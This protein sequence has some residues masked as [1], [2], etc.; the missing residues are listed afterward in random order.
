MPA[1]AV[2]DVFDDNAWEG[3]FVCGPDNYSF[4]LI[5]DESDGSAIRAGIIEFD[6]AA[7]SGR[8]RVRGRIDR[9]DVLFLHDDWIEGPPG[10]GGVG[11]A[12]S[13]HE[14]GIGT[15]GAGRGCENR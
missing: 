13:L 9:R 14:Q 5:V 15:G 12:G 1:T 3:Q 6:T 11:L 4:T 10:L 8:Y 2:A 7:G